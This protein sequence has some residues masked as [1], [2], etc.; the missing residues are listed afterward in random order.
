M[1]SNRIIL[2]HIIRLKFYCEEHMSLG[3]SYIRFAFCKDLETLKA[4]VER[5][6]KLK[7]YLA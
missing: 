1:F 3:E 2:A 5:L 6:Q 7:K 4:A